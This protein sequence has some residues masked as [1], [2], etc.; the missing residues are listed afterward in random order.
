MRTGVPVPSTCVKNRSPWYWVGGDQRVHEAHWLAHPV[1]FM[2]YRSDGKS[3]SKSESV[4]Q[5][6]EDSHADK[7][8]GSERS[9]AGQVELFLLRRKVTRQDACG[10]MARDL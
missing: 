2:S 8:Q 1:L 6:G 5:L 10:E 7:T 4:G 3:V 9:L